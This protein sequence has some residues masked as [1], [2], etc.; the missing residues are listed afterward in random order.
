MNDFVN[1]FYIYCT[2]LPA[3]SLDVDKISLQIVINEIESLQFPGIPPLQGAVN[4]TQYLQ[5]S[6]NEIQFL[7]DSVNEIQSLL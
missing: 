4:E 6:V 5:D 3:W 7:Q 2:I 1:I